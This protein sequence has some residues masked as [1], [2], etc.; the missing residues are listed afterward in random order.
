MPYDQGYR[1]QKDNTYTVTFDDFVSYQ[2][3]LKSTST[4]QSLQTKAY[5]WGY[6]EKHGWERIEGYKESANTNTPVSS[7][8][9]LSNNVFIPVGSGRSDVAFSFRP[10]RNY[11]NIAF[12]LT[13]KPDS[14]QYFS[15]FSIKKVSISEFYAEFEE[16]P[17][18][19]QLTIN[20]TGDASRGGEKI[21]LPFSHYIG[22]FEGNVKI[23][24]FID[25]ESLGT[26]IYDIQGNITGLECGK[27]I[28]FINDEEVYSKDLCTLSKNSGIWLDYNEMKFLGYPMG[29][30]NVS[31]TGLYNGQI[32]SNLK[33]FESSFREELLQEA[34]DNDINNLD[35]KSEAEIPLPNYYVTLDLDTAEV[36]SLF[37][38][39]FQ[40]ANAIFDI[41]AKNASNTSIKTLS[42][43][44]AKI[45]RDVNFNGSS[46]TPYT[47]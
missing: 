10:N 4:D 15:G 1:V 7:Y 6:T 18:G 26:P 29:E 5:L 32:N 23:S 45:V 36:H 12:A 2:K 41:Q 40:E 31:S 46:G 20:M 17:V 30:S 19:T 14:W 11:E 34:I 21:E 44:E 22:L 28:V 13:T 27:M 8:Q 47:P 43:F 9:Q 24:V 37:N 3:S 25:Y 35:V 42:Q 16:G 33:Y 39:G 38:L